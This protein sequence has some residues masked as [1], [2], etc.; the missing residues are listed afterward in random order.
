MTDRLGRRERLLQANRRASRAPAMILA[1]AAVAFPAAAQADVTFGDFEGGSDGWIDWS[2]GQAVIDTSG[3]KWTLT[4]GTGVTK[5]A[6]ALMLTHAGFNQNLAF[7]LQGFQQ[8]H[9]D[10]MADAM[11]HTQIQLD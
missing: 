2:A 5:G 9:P 7:K 1:A 10:F 8:S 11:Q 3:P 4:S 6:S